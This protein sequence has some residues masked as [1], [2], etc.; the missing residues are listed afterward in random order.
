VEVQQYSK[1]AIYPIDLKKAYNTFRKKVS[2]LYTISIIFVM[3]RKL[4]GLIKTYSNETYITVRI[5][6]NLS[7]KFPFRMAWKKE[8]LYD[9]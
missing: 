8:T 6:K 7:D 9:H 1:S 3:P 5:G 2:L 4:V